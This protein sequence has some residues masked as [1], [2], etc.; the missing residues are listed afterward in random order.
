M[1]EATPRFELID[2]KKFESAYF[3]LP[4][5]I[6]IKPVKSF[7]SVCANPVYFRDEL[8]HYVSLSRLPDLFLQ[9]FDWFLKHYSSYE[10]DSHYLIAEELLEGVQ[11][12]LEG[13]V[14]NGRFGVTCIVDSIMFPNKISFKRF[15]YPSSLPKSVQNYMIDISRRF[16]QAINFD[17]GFFNIEF[18]YN[19][20]TNRAHI[21]EVNPRLAS[22]FAEMVE[23]VDGTNTYE[24]LL[25]IVTGQKP[26]MNKKKGAHTMSALFVLRTFQDKKVVS[27]PSQKDIEYFYQEFPDARLQLFV[28]AG[29][30]LSQA[31]QD[32]KSY[33]YGL[34]HLG[35]R[36]RNDILNK[37]ERA[38]QLLP[39]IFAPV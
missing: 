13:Y 4:F 31:F 15:E 8:A 1:P 5:P 27:S 28:T 36:D 29:Q 12:T 21:I 11:S 6:F 23:K 19:P 9:Q 35:G 18:M 16:M 33:R 20:K 3:S 34:I 24:L 22:Q 17:N 14:Y 25:A 30:K 38:K 26:V 32:G 37:F 7:F 39:F 2:L 10:L